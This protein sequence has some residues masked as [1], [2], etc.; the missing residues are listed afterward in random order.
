MAENSFYKGTSSRETLFNLILKL[1]T[2]ELEGDIIL[3]M[4]HVLGKWMIDSG[5]DTLSRE[6]TTMSIMRGNSLLSYFLFTWVHIN[7]VH[8][9]YHGSILGGKEES[10]WY[11]YLR[12]DGLIMCLLK[13]TICGHR[14]LQKIKQQLI[15][16][17]GNIICG[18]RACMLFVFLA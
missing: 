8:N 10:R 7:G 11:I 2:L 15:S 14:L 5:V 6:G 17:A 13:E 9:W 4:I 18:K 1:R 12:M 3:H 16:C